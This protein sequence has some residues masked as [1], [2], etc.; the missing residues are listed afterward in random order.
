MATMKFK[1]TTKHVILLDSIGLPPVPPE[2]VIEVPDALAAPG[3]TD[4]GAR[5]K[6]VIECVAPQLE[7]ADK[8]DMELWLQ[9][10]PAPT[11][12][13]RIVTIARRAP[14]EAPGVRALREMR[15]KQQAEAKK[16]APVVT[17]A[18]TPAK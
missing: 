11:P 7:P 10:P 8:A 2:G 15:A 16:A 4:A 3:R 6:S 5:S 13:S 1:N 17:P 18:P 9:T 12:V 14:Q